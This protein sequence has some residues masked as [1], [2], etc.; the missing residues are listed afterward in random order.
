MMTKKHFEWAAQQVRRLRAS[1][2]SGDSPKC[3]ATEDAYAELFREFGPRFDE[4][5]FRAACAQARP[6]T[7]ERTF[8]AVVFKRVGRNANG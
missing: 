8:R 2:L 5:R 7:D 3:Q 4:S 6:V 1:H